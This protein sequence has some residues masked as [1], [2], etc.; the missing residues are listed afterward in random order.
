MHDRS[1]FVP[2]DGGPRLCSGCSLAQVQMRTVLAMLCRI[3][4]LVPVRS[5]G[6]VGEPLAFTMMP[7]ALAVRPGRRRIIRNG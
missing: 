2:Y 7:A 4:E 1:A 5:G 6:E 3:F